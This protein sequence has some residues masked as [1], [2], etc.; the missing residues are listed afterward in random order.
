MP[1]LCLP[2]YTTT[3]NTHTHAWIRI[4]GGIGFHLARFAS[5]SKLV[6]LQILLPDVSKVSERKTRQFLSFAMKRVSLSLSLYFVSRSTRTNFRIAFSVETRFGSNVT[7][8]AIRRPRRGRRKRSESGR[9]G[10]EENR[11]RVERRGDGKREGWEEVGG[12]RIK[13]RW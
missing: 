4:T 1:A 6:L 3:E 11:W 12:T 8:F 10:M 9:D 5:N 2:E 13:Q 7:R